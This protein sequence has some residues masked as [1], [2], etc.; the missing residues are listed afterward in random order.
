MQ[1]VCV[2]NGARNPIFSLLILFW[3]LGICIARS[4]SFGLRR[5]A[6]VSRR[7][8]MLHGFGSEDGPSWSE[9]Q[10]S[11]KRSLLAWVVV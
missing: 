2:V 3:G 5:S 11:W 1:L 4:S 6:V 7:R 8:S 10:M 9:E